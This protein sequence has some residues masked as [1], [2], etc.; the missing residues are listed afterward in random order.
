MTISC[1]YENHDFCIINLVYKSMFLSDT[2][3]PFSSAIAREWFRFASSSTRMFFQLKFQL[4]KFLKSFGLFISQFPD[5]LNGLFSIFDTISHYSIRSRRS[6]TVS[7]SFNSY[8]GPF[9]ASSTRWKN[10]SFV[11]S[12]GSSF[13][14]T[15]FRKYLTARF[16]SFSSS[17]MM[18][19]FRSN[20]AFN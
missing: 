17:A 8:K 18:L 5:I 2:S 10:S 9:L 6:S 20:S 14:E 13:S 1:K 19:K 7:P 12:V 3:A 16:S 11:N 4:K 15:S